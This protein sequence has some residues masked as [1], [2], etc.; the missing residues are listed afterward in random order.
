MRPIL[1][2]AAVSLALAAAACASAGQPGGDALRN[3]NSSEISPDEVRASTRRTAY[4]VVQALRPEWLRKRSRTAGINASRGV[5]VSDEVTAYRDG[6]RLGTV[7]HLRS[8]PV[9]DVGRIRYY[10]ASAAQQRFGSGNPNGA[11]E[12]LTR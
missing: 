2:A 11:I 3:P 4:E 8:I 12:V 6:Q 7:E 5:A 1:R 10:S 9:G